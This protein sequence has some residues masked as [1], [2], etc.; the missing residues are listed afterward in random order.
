MYARNG[1][2]LSPSKACSRQHTLLALSSTLKVPSL[3]KYIYQ[4]ETL[5]QAGAHGG[6]YRVKL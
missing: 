3:Q 5:F 6:H 4:L 2:G 1:A